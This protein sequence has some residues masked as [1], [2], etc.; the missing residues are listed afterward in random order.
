MDDIPLARFRRVF[1]PLN[2]I[3]IHQG[4]WAMLLLM[5]NGPRI[6]DPGQLPWD[7][8]AIRTGSALLAVLIALL[9]LR[10]MPPMTHS[11]R[12]VLPNAGA[13]S[14]R[15]QATFGI[16]GL[17]AMLSVARLLMEPLSGYAARVV[18][19]GA[20]DALAYHLI[21][22]G[23]AYTLYEE[24]G[25][26]LGAAITSFAVS[27]GLRDLILNI[28]G[29]NQGALAIALI[30]GAILG[31][32]IALIAIGLRKWPGGFWVAWAAQF[33]VITLIAGFV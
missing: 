21:A 15:T 25:W 27:W 31:A 28:I 10:R 24:S 7:W 11:L 16:L 3:L 33:I 5:A 30:G 32:L 23:I 8:W 2:L 14:A 20:V 19:F 9:Y 12:R 4:L 18:I 17:A 6:T 26:G 22:F 13:A 1:R 29:D